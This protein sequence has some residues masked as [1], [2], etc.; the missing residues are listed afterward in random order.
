VNKLQNLCG[1]TAVPQLE[2]RMRSSELQLNTVG[3]FVARIRE[4]RVDDGKMRTPEHSSVT[5][6]VIEELVGLLHE[7]HDEAFLNLRVL[8]RM[9][10]SVTHADKCPQVLVGHFGGR[11]EHSRSQKSVPE[12]D[13]AHW[14]RGRTVP[15]ETWRQFFSSATEEISILAYSS[16]FIAED[17]GLVAVLCAKADEGVRVRIALGD[18]DCPQVAERGKQEDIDLAM[19]AKIRNALVLYRPLS[20]LASAEIRLH[21]TVLY[22]TMY[23]SDGQTLVNQHIYGVPAANSPVMRLSAATDGEISRGYVASFERLWQSLRPQSKSARI[24]TS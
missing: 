11:D 13:G 18:P 16:L 5:S 6:K 17:A 22:N 20:E 1:L 19:A 7:R 24:S 12:A 2:V 4:Q 8:G 15:R 14:A 21:A 23:R 10:R 3:K 9:D